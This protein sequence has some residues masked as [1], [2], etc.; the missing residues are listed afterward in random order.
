MVPW[1]LE[2]V[3]NTRGASILL[4]NIWGQRGTLAAIPRSVRWTAE[5]QR[6]PLVPGK[7]VNFG[8]DSVALF[9]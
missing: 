8:G 6:L 2:H 7:V 4:P 5:G 3:D 9:P 1:T